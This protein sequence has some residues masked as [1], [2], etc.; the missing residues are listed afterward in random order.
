MKEIKQKVNRK[1]EGT[2]YLHDQVPKVGQI[3]CKSVLIRMQDKLFKL[4][5]FFEMLI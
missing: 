2:W 5:C 1:I 3:F 4:S